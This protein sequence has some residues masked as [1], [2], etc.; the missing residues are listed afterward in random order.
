MNVLEVDSIELSFGSRKI[1]KDVYMKCE[2]G[3]VTG[4]IGR[5]GSGKSCLL[6]VLFG[7]LSADTQS[8]RFN[9]QYIKRAHEV[10]GLLAFLP[11][12]GY[13]MDYL[14]C[15]QLAGIHRLD[16]ASCEY[17]QSL[18]VVQQHYHEPIGQISTGLRKLIEVLVVLLSP[19]KFILLDEPFSF[20]APVLVE[21]VIRVIGAQA[22]DKGI[23]LTDHLYK[24]VFEVCDRHYLLVDGSLKPVSELSQLSQ[25][26]YINE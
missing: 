23:V 25:Y 14:S 7:A 15:A 17:L 20:L 21:E 10:R 6:R 13:A 5:N 1:L 4:L 22:P 9:G 12:D 8:V 11:Q 26:G 2:T 3:S 24:H 18:D 19:R 16:D